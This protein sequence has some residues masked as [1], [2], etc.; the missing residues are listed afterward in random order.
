MC[1]P[2]GVLDKPRLLG[3]QQSVHVAVRPPRLRGRVAPRPR[4]DESGQGIDRAERRST[5]PLPKRCAMSRPALAPRSRCL[6][7]TRLISPTWGRIIELE[8]HFKS[9]GRSCR[10]TVWCRSGSWLGTRAWRRRLFAITSGSAC[11]HSPSVPASEG[12][13]R[14]RRRG[15]PRRER[16]QISLRP[17]TCASGRLER[18]D[19]S[20]LPGAVVEQRIG[21][22]LLPERPRHRVELDRGVGGLQ[23]PRWMVDVRA[24][25]SPLL[26]D[27]V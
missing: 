21:D 18:P 24:Q 11:C 25:R 7:L 5:T 20:V 19:Q 26:V 16:E 23:R 14:R 4:P 2:G 3:R 9:R 13:T 22:E 17:L 12:A 15:V 10:R 27:H 8:V 6:N 1:E